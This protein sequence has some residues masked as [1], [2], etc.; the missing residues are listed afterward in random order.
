VPQL[1]RQALIGEDA[2]IADPQER[3]R[4]LCM[5]AALA[6]SDG[7]IT[8][9]ERKLLEL[10]ARRWSIPWSDVETA[11]DAGPRLFTRLVP[12]ESPAAEVFLRNLV[13]IAR[14][15]GRIDREASGDPPGPPRA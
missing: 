9:T 10:Y 6:S 5:M 2:V 4:L 8:S 3:Q 15:D 1:Q 12:R 14:V 7:L 13:E 11:L